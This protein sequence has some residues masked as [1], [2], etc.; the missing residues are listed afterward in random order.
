MDFSY[1]DSISERRRERRV[2]SRNLLLEAYQI[3][4]PENQNAVSRDHIMAVM[5]ILNQDVPEIQRLSKEERG[6]IFAFLDKDGSSTIS[7]DEFLDFG[8]ILLLRLTKRSDYATFVER[9]LPHIH[10]SIWY[11]SLCKLVK[12]DGFESFLDMLLVLNAIVIGVQDYPLLAGKDVTQD[13]HFRDGYIDTV[14]E[15]LE[16]IFTVIYVLEVAVKV[17]VNGWK[18]YSES[19][20]NMFDFFITILALL[21]SAY[22]YCKLFFIRTPQKCCDFGIAFS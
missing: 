22:V 20:R 12:S 13:P 18:R 4:D 9:N 8:K 14:W 7:R 16:T 5:L 19:M 17:L 10:Q 21:A 15:R 1:D 3:L 11:Q 6:I 2:L